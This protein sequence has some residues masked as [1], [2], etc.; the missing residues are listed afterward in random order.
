MGEDVKAVFTR[1][2]FK[3]MIMICNYNSTLYTCLNVIKAELDPSLEPRIRDTV[4]QHVSKFFIYLDNLFHNNKMYKQGSQALIA[5]VGGTQFSKA[6]NDF[7][8]KTCSQNYHKRV[9]V[10]FNNNQ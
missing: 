7:G 1:S 8:D 3:N 5:L 6:I 4:L 2:L 9:I 10:P